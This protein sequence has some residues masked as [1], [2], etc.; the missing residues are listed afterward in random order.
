[1]KLEKTRDFDQKEGGGGGEAGVNRLRR[2]KPLSVF[3]QKSEFFGY[4]LEMVES[5]RFTGKIEAPE[6]TL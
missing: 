2:V 1:M 5:K 6:V 3:R 4:C